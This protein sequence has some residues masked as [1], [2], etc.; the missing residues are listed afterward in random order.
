MR[1]NKSSYS[2]GGRQRLGTGFVILLLAW[3][4]LVHAQQPPAQ[5][6]LSFPGAPKTTMAIAW[7]T[8]GAT[9]ATLDYW[10]EGDPP[11]Q[12]SATSQR[13]VRSGVR[14]T[15][16]L[17]DLVAGS[18]YHYRIGTSEATFHTA[19]ADAGTAVTF[20]ALGD[21]RQDVGETNLD[22]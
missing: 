16:A 13:L 1:R 12:A 6:T 15:V 11:Q 5:L 22:R 4:G 2:P 10:R 7:T 14:H 18:I 17:R 19:P 20:V 8:P 21:S 9:P 3:A